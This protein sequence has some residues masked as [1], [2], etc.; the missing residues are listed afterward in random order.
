MCKLNTLLRPAK[1]A[2]LCGTILVS[3]CMGPGTYYGNQYG[4]P[5][6]SPPQAIGNGM[7][8][9][10]L[11]IPESNA[12]PYAPSGSTGTYES[13]PPNSQDDFNLPN[14]E[15]FYQSE[16]SGGVPVPPDRNLNQF[17]SELGPSAQYKAPFAGE[18][19]IQLVSATSSASEY[20]FDTKDYRWLRGVL[21]Y[22]SRSGGWLITYSLAARD[23]FGG[24][25]PID[26]TQQQINGL[27]EGDTVDLRGYVDETVRNQ[28]GRPV[29]RVE[30]IER[31]DI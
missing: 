25:L 18:S 8:P 19:D 30:F 14:R 9:G 12:P 23:E 20:G 24:T 28:Q 10:T 3:G 17:N 15:P 13:D 5:M 6:Y 1:F 26:V 27:A 21:N 11:Y 29:Y 31:I 4:Q 22:D 2:A 16:D 7:A